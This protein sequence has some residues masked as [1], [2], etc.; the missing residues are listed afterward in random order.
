MVLFLFS[1]VGHLGWLQGGG[2]ASRGCLCMVSPGAGA[3]SGRHFD[4]AGDFTASA[5]FLLDLA[6]V[7]P[8]LR[9]NLFHFHTSLAEAVGFN[10]GAL[11]SSDFSHLSVLG[12]GR[13]VVNDLSS[14]FV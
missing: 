13:L 1:L 11:G 9:P 4:A 3:G 14:V 12:F 8:L 2:S 10:A 5:E 7:P 6:L